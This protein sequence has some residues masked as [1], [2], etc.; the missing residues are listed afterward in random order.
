MN[1]HKMIKVHVVYHVSFS[2]SGQVSERKNK[3]TSADPGNL[4][5]KKNITMNIGSI[6]HTNNT[7][8]KET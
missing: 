7:M 3:L 1:T 8:A 6:S 2:Y 4:T 5:L